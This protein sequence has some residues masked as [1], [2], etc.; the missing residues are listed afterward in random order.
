M[1]LLPRSELLAL[2]LCSGFAKSEL[3]PIDTIDGAVADELH[4]AGRE[5]MAA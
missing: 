1:M 3:G 5:S 4:S 2:A